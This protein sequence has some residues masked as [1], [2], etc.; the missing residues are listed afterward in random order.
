MVAHD[1]LRTWPDE[2]DDGFYAARL[3]PSGR[4]A[5][6]GALAADRERVEDRHDRGVDR[7]LRRASAS[8]AA[9]PWATST[10]SPSP[11]PTVS[12][13]TNAS[14][15]SAPALSAGCTS[16][17]E[18][19]RRDSV[20]T[21]ATAWPIT[22][23]TIIGISYGRGARARIHSTPVSWPAGKLVLPSI[24][25][26]DFGAFRSQVVELLDAGARGFHVDVMDG[27]FVP[28]IT[29]GPRV[30]SSFADLVH[31]R[32]GTIDVHLM[33]EQP[34]RQLAEFAKAGADSCT[35]HVETCPHLH[36][37]LA[38][39]HELGMTAGATLNPAT[40]TAALREAAREADVLLC[41]SVDP[42]WGGQRFIEA[43][44][45]RLG[46]LRGDAAAGHGARGR[47]RRRAGDDR[48]LPRGRR[49]PD[50][51]G[52]GDLRPAVAR[53]GLEGARR[54]SPARERARRG[55]AR[56]RARP[57]RART[58]QREPE[59]ASSAA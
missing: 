42:G 28:V 33:I 41:M 19:A 15:A 45:E 55:A 11:A 26:A 56:P 38:L 27:H 54:R 7:A 10:S 39:I 44:I 48:A 43:S 5:R 24:L 58:A 16:I 52:L 49:E 22:R 30:V 57:G 21:V 18:T 8:R 51:G 20:L 9:E 6:V 40:P 53:R 14:P 47:R 35:V 36:Q 31:E 59:P 25:S 2:G 29:F 37:T 46:E 32:G 23:Q 4:L 1:E 34:E 17:S 50:G 3:T 13:A 12:T